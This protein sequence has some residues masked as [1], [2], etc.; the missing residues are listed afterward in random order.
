MPSPSPA[1]LQILNVHE[2][3]PRWKKKEK[4]SSDSSCQG[5]SKRGKRKSDQLDEG[6]RKW[7]DLVE[8]I[9]TKVLGE[10]QTLKANGPTIDDKLTSAVT[11][12]SQNE[13]ASK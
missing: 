8:E 4:K 7:V 11:K 10:K 2:R 6:I 3:K 1:V 9:L 12:F 13:F 5:S